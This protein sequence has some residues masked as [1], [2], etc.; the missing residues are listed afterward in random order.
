[1][2][3]RL[4]LTRNSQFYKPIAQLTN[5][6]VG[7]MLESASV[8]IE[9]NSKYLINEIRQSREIGSFQYTY[10]VRV[11]PTQREVYFLS[12]N[13]QDRIYAY[14]LILEIDDYVALFRK[15]CA[16]INKELIEYFIAVD[17]DQLTA[18]FND[19]EVEFQKLA[20]RN[21]TMSDRAL[22]ARSYEAANLKGLLSTHAAGRSI[23]YFLRIRLGGKIK[24]INTGSGRVVENSEREGIDTIALWAKSQVDLISNPAINNDFL[25]A[26]AS[27]I[28]LEKVLENSSPKAIMFETGMM[29]DRLESEDV[30]IKY[31]TRND[32]YIKIS[33]RIIDKLFKALQV[34]YE[35]DDNN[36]F[37]G[38]E[39][40]SSLKIN[41]KKLS[42]KSKSLAKFKV[43][44]NS[45]E[46]TLPGYL[47]KNG[48]YSVCFSN[49]KYMYF[50]GACFEDESG[51]SE[52][53]SILD[54]F[55][56]V[57]EILGV[58]SEKGG[59]CSNSINFSNDSMFRVIEKLHSNDDYIFCDDLGDEWADHITLNRDDSSICFIHSKHGDV[60]RS[61]SKF[62]DV[63]GQGI[64]N[65][66][67]MFF[68]KNMLMEK[69]GKTFSKFYKPKGGGINEYFKGK[70]R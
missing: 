46:Y 35:L 41:K 2:P 56:P 62:Q 10:S 66:G 67:N 13:I 44:E 52:I 39:A 19:D 15:S 65:L 40:D 64:K 20:T 7:R 37:I 45:S 11:F 61:A 60:S 26:F 58:G 33:P 69:N 9:N 28:E 17:H 51:I 59:F 6:I 22:R 4:K 24:T 3:D 18:T 63:V 16:N 31:K 8:S 29:L 23:P 38:Y 21:M 25:D 5:S 54:I 48:W 36:N 27:K 47:I 32:R 30:I 70:K 57:S 1:M 43:F 53:S 55:H 68:T 50:M 42:F 14:I 49:P 34:V 12:D